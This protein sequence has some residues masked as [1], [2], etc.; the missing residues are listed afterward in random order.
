MNPVAF[1]TS[2]ALLWLGALQSEPVVAAQSGPREN[3][4]EARSP[5]PLWDGLEAGPFAVGFE[6]ELLVDR[7]R[8]FD[9]GAGTDGSDSPYAARPIRLFVW[10]PASIGNDDHPMV[11]GDYL[12]PTLEAGSEYS[13][14][15]DLLT[16][17]DLDTAKR[18]FRP[19]SDLLVEK[20]LS[21]LTAAF[22]HAQPVPGRRPL[23]LHS[24]GRN[25]FQQ[26]STVLFEYLASHGF[27][28]ATVPQI[29]RSV[30]DDR[31]AF[32]SADL[33][34]QKRD[35][36]FALAHLV[37][38]DPRVDPRRIA[39]SGHSAG[40]IAMMLLAA[41][42][43]NVDALIALEGSQATA[44]GWDLLRANSWDPVAQQ[45]PFLD[46]Q[47]TG[48]PPAEDRVWAGMKHADRLRIVI[49]GRDDGLWTTHFDFQNWPLYAILT[50]VEDERGQPYRSMELGRDTY[51]AVC[52]LTQRFL[53]SVWSTSTELGALEKPPQVRPDL[54]DVEYSPRLAPP[55]EID[56]H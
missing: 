14:Y 28:V 34:V 53:G 8:S 48:K 25:D 49:G 32:E 38:S 22:Q 55:S 7:S 56:D 36:G 3:P 33:L 50:G 20:L 29:G 31:L 24:L 39:F 4:A 26:E 27:V 13:P 16:A 19:S 18:Q 40:A 9:Q 12:A 46:L 47:A 5:S 54:V 6:A 42:N 21:T 44:E 1:C 15:L 51:L 35:L 41:E 23:L 10:Y 17:R 2:L 11:F 43:A 45:V 37:G 30:G 52:S